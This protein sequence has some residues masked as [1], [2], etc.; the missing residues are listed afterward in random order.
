[1]RPPQLLLAIALGCGAA[2]WPAGAVAQ[3][4]AELARAREQFRQ[5]LALEA[6]GNWTRA[7]EIFKSVAEI[8]STAQVRYHV[9]LCEE[10]T[11]DWVQ[12]IGSYRMALVEA[13]QG[14]ARDVIDSA[15]QGIDALEPKIP[16]LTVTRGAGAAVADLRLDGK[17]LGPTLV[18]TAFAVNPG[19]HVIEA[20]APDRKPFRLEFDLA[21]GATRSVHLVLPEAPVDASGPPV[22][23][24]PAPD[25]PS[26]GSALLPV[27]I[28][29]GV[30]GL[31]SL[32]VAGVF[33]GLRAGNISDLES[34]CGGAD[35]K[36]CPASAREIVADGERNSTIST[37]TFIGGLGAVALGVVLVIVAPRGAPAETPA[38]M[39]VVP[40]GGRHGGGVSVVGRF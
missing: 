27:G 10:K 26:G 16:K 20:S 2:A 29:V 30:L 9:A 21:E 8:K 17:P 35:G 33:Y 5:G 15:R 18:G 28:T 22:E 19:P 37:A 6:A 4:K 3:P 34:Q 14:K 13:E 31:A 36:T 23:P 39:R 32:G 40:S 1:V 12:A 24:P 11:G 38:A 25:A 7:L